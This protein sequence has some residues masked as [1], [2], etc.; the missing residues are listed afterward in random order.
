MLIINADDWGGW[1][2]ATD[3]ALAC[4]RK[5]CITSVTAM[6]F[7]ADSAR[8]ASLARETGMD[9]GLHL[10]LD[11]P[12]TGGNC[13]ENARRRHNSVCRWLRSGKYAQVLFNPFLSKHFHETFKAQVVE[14]E[15]LY[16]RKPS[17]VDGHHHLH[18][19]ANMLWGNIIPERQKVRRNFSFWPGQKSFLN[20]AYRSWVD[21]RLTRRHRTTDYFFALS[22]CFNS[23]G[24]ARIA[25]V[26]AST[27]VELMTHPEKPEEYNWLMGDKART[28]AGSLRLC[29][30]AQ[31]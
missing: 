27:N 11:T 20:R 17:H 25:E 26:A 10:N 8:A 9:V 30:Y 15:R 24:F 7:M 2:S 21:K 12:F 6:V 31:L 5:G 18:L 3:A 16:G 28:L 14:F 19:C 22:G 13:P 29:S 1:E 4:F 23:A